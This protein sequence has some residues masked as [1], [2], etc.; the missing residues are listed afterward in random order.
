MTRRATNKQIDESPTN[1]PAP[2]LAAQKS[3]SRG[4]I[5]GQF[6][7]AP[8]ASTDEWVYGRFRQWENSTK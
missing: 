2:L 8:I 3:T 1:G 4:S 5:E 6:T 7:D